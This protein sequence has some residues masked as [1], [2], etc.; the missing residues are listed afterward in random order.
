METS[1]TVPIVR[2]ALLR[3]FVA[4]AWNVYLLLALIL[5]S[6]V[7]AFAARYD[8]P[9]YVVAGVLGIFAFVGSVFSVDFGLL[10][11]VFLAYTRLSDIAVHNY[12][13]VSVLQLFMVLLVA[14]ILF[15]WA[16]FRHAPGGALLPTVLLGLYGIAASASIL[17]AAKPSLVVDGLITFV[18]DAIIAI[19]IVLLLQRA[20]SFRRVLWILI[21]GGVFLGTL[22]SWQFLSR[23]FTN[24]YGGFATAAIMQIVGNTN[25]Y[26]IG[27]PI[28]DPNYFAQILVVVVPIAMERF[29]HERRVLLRGVALWSALVCTA[30]TIFTYSRGGFFALAV[31]VAAFF[32]FYPP[33]G[34]QLPVFILSMIAIVMI[35]PQNYWAR[36]MALNQYLQT[37]GVIRTSDPAL[38]SRAAENLT[39]LE[40]IKASPVIGV[41]WKNYNTVYP[42][43]AKSIGISV[44]NGP[45][46]AAHDLYLEVA[47]ETGFVGLALFAL[48]I[49][50][51]ARS[52]W[53]ARQ[54]FLES[55]LAEYSHMITGFGL[56]FMSYLV[57]SLFIHG[58]F[59]RYLYLL[60]GI[61]FALRQVVRNTFGESTSSVAAQGVPA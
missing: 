40:M 14:A 24:N 39:A 47:A 26:R 44:G 43:Y 35:L 8:R 9:L 1:K 19:V 45:G 16:I 34:F 29:L 37:P 51:A 36:I 11:L 56:A 13:F 57:A 7:G 46:I 21:W 38:R 4:G 55:K 61:A 42:A 6:A 32:V 33:R 54:R 48:L 59:P 10:T 53:N 52:V 41:G 28:G 31:V 50:A 30:A 5:G 49:A 58:A 27:G 12:H 17:D 2:P 25:D 18:K 23:T 60:L 15:R 3:H 22:S 20:S